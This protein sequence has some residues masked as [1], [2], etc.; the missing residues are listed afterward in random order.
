MFPSGAPAAISVLFFSAALSAR[1]DGAVFS[2]VSDVF[3]D[4][5]YA[6]RFSGPSFFSASV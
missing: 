6:V 4:F 3:E 5:C 1:P 2:D